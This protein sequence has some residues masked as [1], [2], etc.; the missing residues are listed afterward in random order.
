M[1]T[2]SLVSAATCLWLAHNMC[3]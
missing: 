3:R 2:I 1:S